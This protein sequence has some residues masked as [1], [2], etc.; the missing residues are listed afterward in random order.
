MHKKAF[1]NSL[2]SSPPRLF[3]HTTNRHGGDDTVPYA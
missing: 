3:V 1:N 2:S